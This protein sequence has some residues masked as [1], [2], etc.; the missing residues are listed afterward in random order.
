MFGDAPV[1]YGVMFVPNNYFIYLYI[2]IYS[3]EF[4]CDFTEQH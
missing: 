1:A 2:Y 4:F 3:H